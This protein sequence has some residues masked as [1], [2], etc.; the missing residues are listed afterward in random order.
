[1]YCLSRLNCG[2]WNRNKQVHLDSQDIP[3]QMYDQWE[4]FD[5]LVT[6]QDTVKKR[7][8]IHPKNKSEQENLHPDQKIS[9]FG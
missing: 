7:K 2:C 3:T 9:V 6:K 5:L 4:S 1:M 8:I